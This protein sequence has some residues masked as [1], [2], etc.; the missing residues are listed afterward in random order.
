MAEWLILRLP[1]AADGTAGWLVVDADGRPL[2]PLQSG[3]LA[4]A[5]ADAAGRR[6]AVL[7]PAADVLLVDV[8]LPAGASGRAAQLA[9]FALEE[10]LVGNVEDQHFAIGRAHDGARVPV[11][12]VARAQMQG[13]LAQL[14]AAGIEASML[15]AEHALL[16]A[17]PGQCVAT[18]EGSQLCLRDAAG[19]SHCIEASAG[20][21][22]GALE[23][24][25]GESRIASALMIYTTPADWQERRAEIEALRPQFADLKAQLLNHGLLPWLAAYVPTAQAINLLQGPYAP[26]AARGAAW[27]RWRLAASLAAGLLVL[28]LGVQGWRLYQL[29]RGEGALDEQLHALAGSVPPGPGSLRSRVEQALL[30]EQSSDEHAGLLP[31]MQAVADALRVVPGARVQS[32]DFRDGTLQLKLHAADAQSL[33]QVNQALRQSGW[34]SQLVSGAPSGNAYEGSLRVA[35]GAS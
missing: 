13:W 18:L 28:H 19:T 6:V 16:P 23:L 7:A 8:E 14:Q 32:F 22:A 12:V 35:R 17:I 9:P 3:P 30:A 4:G 29:D 26:R 27:Q 25:L 33:E 5:A 34:Q 10:Q 11:A 15:L 20:S 2:K 31:V 24:L 1:R 21:L